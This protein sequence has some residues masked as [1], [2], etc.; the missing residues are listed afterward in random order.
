MSYHLAAS[1]VPGDL[2]ADV[3]MELNDNVVG[4]LHF[5]EACLKSGVNR[6]VFSSSS[7]VY[8]TQ[9]HLPIGE[10]APTNPISAHG[11]HKLSVE[12]YLLLARRL[13]GIEVRI[14]RIGNPYGPEQSPIGRQGFVAIAIGEILRRSPLPLRDM[15]RT[16]R[17][18]IY[19]DDLAEAMA[20][21]GL[22]DGLPSI[23]NIGTGRGY[24]LREVLEVIEG[25]I[26]RKVETNAVESRIV[27]IQESVLDVR[28]A[29]EVLNYSPAIELPEG[30]RMTLRFH[31]I[32]VL[33]DLPPFAAPVI[34]QE[35]R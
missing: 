23:I 4:A 33:G 5:I 16:V 9:D 35:V 12:K 10:S 31:G 30:I 22:L 26:G 32:P 2:Y 34:R 6:I 24:S 17:D 8:G 25:L 11:I 7:S 27:D 18:F 19:I 20:L 1:T 29:K 15:G 21:A 13:H 14:L 28:L 3:A